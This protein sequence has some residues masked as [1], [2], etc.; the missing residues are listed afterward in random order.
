MTISDDLLKLKTLRDQGILSEEEFLNQKEKLLT[1]NNN[2]LRQFQKKENK[3]TD[4]NKPN[5][6][7]L[8]LKLI[9]LIISLIV[10]FVA[11]IGIVFW[12][13]R[14][15]NLM[16]VN[17]RQSLSISYLKMKSESLSRKIVS[18][19]QVRTSATSKSADSSAGSEG[20]YAPK[21]ATGLMNIA[22]IAQGNFSSIQGTW[23]SKENGNGQVILVSG[24]TITLYDNSD[25]SIPHKAEFHY[26]GL[27]YS[28]LGMAS[29]GNVPVAAT[30]YQDSLFFASNY[31][32][33]TSQTIPGGETLEFTPKGKNYLYGSGSVNAA[34]GYQIATQDSISIGDTGAVPPF[35]KVE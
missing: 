4:E 15:V 31:S 24:N 30:I 22:Q 27:V 11:L 21:E 6:R 20:I 12:T 25:P 17:K 32:S 9:S 3:L 23:Q 7:K 29:T 16:A 33:N 18:E 26:V 14:Q 2:S 13:N 35:Y 19:S 34:K 10:V 28:A 5:G 1:K 8:N